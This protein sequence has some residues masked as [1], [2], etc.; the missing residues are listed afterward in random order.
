MG[1]THDRKALELHMYVELAIENTSFST[2]EA[3]A[4]RLGAITA[5]AFATH[6]PM[7]SRVRDIDSIAINSMSLALEA[8]QSRFDRTDVWHVS[9][10]EATTLRRTAGQLDEAIRLLPYNVIRRAESL[11]AH[12]LTNMTADQAAAIINS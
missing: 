6:G 9:Q 8:I 12:M 4:R 3:L 1:T 10:E 7:K 2:L 11:V 5:A